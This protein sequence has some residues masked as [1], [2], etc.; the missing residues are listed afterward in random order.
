MIK[1]IIFFSVIISQ[2]TISCSNNDEPANLPEESL[3]EQIANITTQ[4]YSKLT[5]SQ[6]K[7]KLE[8]EANDMLVQ[9]DKSKTSGAIEAIQNLGDLISISS[10]DIFD[11]KNDNEIADILNVSG[12]YGIYTWNNSKQI[13]IKT[14]STTELKFVFPAKKI[15]TVNNASLSSKSNS[16]NIK[17]KLE[18]TYGNWVY[19]PKT[20]D[21]IQT[22]SINDEFYLPTSVDATLTID[23]VQAATF[24]TNA[25]YNGT[26]E[27][28][29]ESSFKMVLNDGYT[30]EISGSKKATQNTAKSSFTY[31]GK[32]LVSFTSGSTADIDALIK[33]D[34]L[35]QYQGKANGLIQI[36]D[37]FI[38]VADMDITTQTKDEEALD[39]SLVYPDYPD[40][41]SPK[42]DYK[43]YYTAE[44]TYNKKYSEG[45]VINSNKNAKLILVSKKEGTEIA[46]VV[47]RSEKGYSYDT[48][49]PVWVKDNST[50]GGYWSYNG[51]GEIIT[52]QY[53]DEV[54]YLKFGD[55][56]EVAMSSY[57]STGFDDLETKFED[58]L[59]SFER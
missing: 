3:S 51:N 17:V 15:Q 41:Q 40:Y 13:W 50:A 44:N 7:V 20:D 36:M 19:D 38:I 6:Q 59:K 49:L 27:T 10:V 33:D 23:N 22:P 48:E 46:D 55:G 12:V 28:P 31:N 53:Y 26:V 58:F 47:Y 42:T 14:T 43:A 54:L 25:K 2:L 34:N 1:K 21:Y 5:P 18:D 39:K 8:A 56:T 57:F 4:P 11:G 30:Y 37:N 35:I 32:N 45:N 52:M 16:S 29:D 9:M 24:A